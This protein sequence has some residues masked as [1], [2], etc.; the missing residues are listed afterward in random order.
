MLQEHLSEKEEVRPRNN[1]AH[2]RPIPQ[3]L[4]F[5]AIPTYAPGTN[6]GLGWVHGGSVDK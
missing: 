3:R 1:G 5:L 6:Q 4:S 2:V